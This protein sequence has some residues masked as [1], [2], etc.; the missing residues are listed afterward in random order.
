MDRDSC[1]PH[2]MFDSSTAQ[3]GMNLLLLLFLVVVAIRNLCYDRRIRI[4]RRDD[5]DDD[6]DDNDDAVLLCQ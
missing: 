3:R 6:D 5:D 4:H 1:P 2:A